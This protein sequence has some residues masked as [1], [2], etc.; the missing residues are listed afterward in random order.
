[1]YSLVAVQ[2]TEK[3]INKIKVLGS[4]EIKGP[5]HDSQNRLKSPKRRTVVLN[6]D[7][8]I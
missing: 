5:Q 3:A 1:M 4:K 6:H 8:I 7:N 2:L